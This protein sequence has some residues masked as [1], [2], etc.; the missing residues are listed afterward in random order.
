VRSGGAHAPRGGVSGDVVDAIVNLGNRR[1]PDAHIARTAKYSRG[2]DDR[3]SKKK[4]PRKHCACEASRT[5]VFF[6]AP[7]KDRT[8]DLRMND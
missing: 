3:T 1:D 5:S 7:T 8:L 4:K 2:T 6:G